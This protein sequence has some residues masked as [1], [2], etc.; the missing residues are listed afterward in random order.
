VLRLSLERRDLALEVVDALEVLVYGGESKIR[1]LV[2][3]A[4]P[5]KDLLPDVVGRG[6]AGKASSMLDPPDQGIDG[7]FRDRSIGKGALDTPADLRRVERL[8]PAVAF[9][10]HRDHDGPLERRETLP[11]D[12]ALSPSSNRPTVVGGPAVDHSGIF[13]RAVG[14]AHPV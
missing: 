2:E 7:L 9:E 8:S 1:D 14:A 4:K 11:A 12:G 10:H 5:G 6:L 3:I 13:D